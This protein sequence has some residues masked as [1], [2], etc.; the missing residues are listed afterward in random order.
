MSCEAAEKRDML[1]TR[2]VKGLM[3]VLR[4]PRED[5]VEVLEPS[6]GEEDD[7]TGSNIEEGAVE[8]R[9]EALPWVLGLT[10]RRETRQD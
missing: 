3:E 2:G 8:A 7:A 1:R 5:C 9:L 4:D 10:S 6:V